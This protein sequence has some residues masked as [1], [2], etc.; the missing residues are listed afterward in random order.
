MNQR[1][2]VAVAFACVACLANGPVLAAN[3]VTGNLITFNADGS[4]SWYM[5][6]R[7]LIDN[8]RDADP[9]NDRLLVASVTSSPETNRPAGAVDVVSFDPASGDRSRFQLADIQEDDHND[10]GLLVLPDGRYLAM[11]SNHGNAG[12]LGDRWTRWRVSTNPRDASSWATERTFDWYTA[13]GNGPNPPARVNVSYHNLYYL[14]EEDR[15]YNFSRGTHQAPN[16]L[17]YDPTDNTAEWSGQLATSNTGGYSTGYF[18]Y[19]SNNVDRIH[20]IGTETHPRDFN[21]SIYAGYIEGGKSYAMDGT[22]RDGNIFDN[23]ETGG[24]ASAVP[25]IESFTRV[26]QADPYPGSPL[27]SAAWTT[28][29][30]IGPDG[31]PYALFTSRWKD[32]DPTGNGDSYG[33]NEKDNNGF[34][35]HILHYARFD[36]S[37]WHS[38]PVARMGQ[39]LYDTEEDYTGLGAIDPSDPNTI[40][41]SAPLDPRNA[42]DPPL[43]P[44][45]GPIDPGFLWRPTY[46]VLDGPHEIYKGVTADGGQTWT[47][48]PITENSSVDNFRPIVPTWD[49]DHTAIVWFR[50]TYSSAQNIDA[51]VVGIVEQNDTTTG[52]I[53]YVDATTGN[54]G[55]ATGAGGFDPGPSASEGSNDNL[56]HWRTDTGNG[57]N[58]LASNATN[59]TTLE[60]SPVLQTTLSGLG[61]GT[62]D[63]FAYF[64]ANPSQDWRIQAGLSADNLMLYRDNGAQIAEESQFDP[65][66][67]AVMLSAANGSTLYRAYVGRADVVAGSSIDVFIDDFSFRGSETTAGANRT[68]YDGLGYALVSPLISILAGDYNDDGTVDAADYIV[69]RNGLGTTYTQADYDVWRANFG[70]VTLGV[71]S[72][73]SAVLTSGDP[74]LAAVPEP[75]ALLICFAAMLVMRFRRH[76]MVW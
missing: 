4:W 35:H 61:D 14:S 69:W 67:P 3:N 76:V 70:R 18:K 68:W 36:G 71:G 47:W 9:R 24:G 72:G 51:A 13:P 8:S 50:G 41:I 34:Y 11:Y 73:S 74:L 44:N 22:L 62:Y 65:L 21:N 2:C 7:V 38:Y 16:I 32:D 58:V 59:T 45:R 55:V 48:T 57:G 20:F 19:A 1:N 29:L 23:P 63:V 53:H 40:Y 6:E 42:A 64:W 60:N 52:L 46:Q 15:V 27:Y 37:Q 17:L 39:M 10:A 54:T 30:A 49:A 56:W 33:N 25:N 66:D 28:D 75:P 5:D 31:N 12:G 43:E 26:F